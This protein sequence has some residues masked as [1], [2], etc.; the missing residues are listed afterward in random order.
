[1]REISKEIKR[2]KVNSKIEIYKTIDNNTE[3]K[4]RFDD[5]TV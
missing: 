2:A 1:V 3:V 4:V 5:E